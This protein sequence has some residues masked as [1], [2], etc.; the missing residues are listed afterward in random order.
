LPLNVI[1]EFRDSFLSDSIKMEKDSKI[2]VAGHRGLVGSALVRRLEAQGYSNLVTRAHGQLD[3]TRQAAVDAFFEAEAPEYVLL[4][5]ARVGGILANSTY[6]AEF[7]YENLAMQ[8]HL[9]HAAWKH[10]VKR[11]LFLG[12]SCIYPRECPQPM[13]EAYL[14]SGPLEPTNEPYALAKI[15]GIK[16]CQAYNRQYGTR[17][18]AVMPTNLY[19][20]RDS[21]DLEN[22]H[23]LPA[24]IRKFHL[25][26]AAAAGDWE[27]IEQDEKCYGLI[28]EDFRA[29]L[30]SIARDKGHKA[31]LGLDRPLPTPAVLLWGSGSPRREFLHVDDLAAACLFVLSLDENKFKSLLVDYPSP[32]LN[33][34]WG[35]DHTIRDLAEIVMKIVGFDGDLA[36]DSARPDGTPRKLLDISRIKILGWHPEIS[37]ADGIEQPCRWY[38]DNLAGKTGLP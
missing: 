28:P 5:A 11:L 34:G 31:P 22:S 10:N 38:R 27:S 15:A 1:C 8:T 36:F 4:A 35:R 19:G 29:G 33:I 17:F 26:K 23:V 16:M 25:A 18:L 7:I 24:L 30:I 13:K 37:L 3:L 32:L 21:F 2:Y 6:P 9:I 20:P 12:S 14:L